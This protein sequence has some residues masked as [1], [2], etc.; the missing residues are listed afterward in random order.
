MPAQMEEEFIKA[1]PKWV[2]ELDLMLKKK[3]KAEIQARP[4]WRLAAGGQSTGRGACCWRQPPAW[5]APPLLA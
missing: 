1:N 3:E 2:T 5:P 4:G